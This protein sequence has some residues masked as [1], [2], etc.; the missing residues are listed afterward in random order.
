M[1][2]NRSTAFI[3]SF[4][5]LGSAFVTS[6]GQKPPGTFNRP[7]TFDAQNYTIRASFDPAQKKV[8]GETT[9]SLKPLKPDFRIVEL[10][11]VDLTF[12][13][14]K[15]DPAGT[16]LQYTTDRGKVFVTL[17]KA[18]GPDDLISIRFKYSAHPTK[19]VYF[20][21]AETAND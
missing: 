4:L 1:T 15:L 21:D 7:Q 13:S 8:F 20:V 18:Y 10:D 12:E 6:Y 3:A 2:S 11:A 17:D 19:G 5:I 14:I 9:V 16:D